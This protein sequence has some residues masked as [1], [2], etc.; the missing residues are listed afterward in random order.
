MSEIQNNEGSNVAKHAWTFDHVS[1]FDNSTI[2][3]KGNN[4][5][6]AHGQNC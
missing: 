1:D 4:H 6:M 3:D 5:M 2:I